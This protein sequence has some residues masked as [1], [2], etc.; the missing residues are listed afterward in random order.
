MKTLKT[1]FLVPVLD[2]VK[3]DHTLCLEIRYK[4]IE[5]YYRGGVILKIKEGRNSFT[6]FF[7][8]NYLVEEKTKVPKKL[9]YLLES[10]SDVK[11]WIN[12]VPFLKHEMDLWFGR[13]PKKEREFQ[14]LMLREN[15]FG[16]TATGTDYFI[17]DIE[18]SKSR[19]KGRF[20]LIAVHWPSSGP[21]RKNNKNLGLAFMEMKYLDN[22]LK[23]AAGLK[24]HIEDLNIF[25][26]NPDN[27]KS[28]KD[29]M[30]T[31]F[32][33]KLELGLVNNQKSIE[34]FN[35]DK[36]EYI[37]VFINHDP[38]AS[39]LRDELRKLPDCPNAELKISTSNFMGYGLYD[40]GIYELD[41]FLDKF[42]DCV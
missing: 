35:D 42:N 39:I 3:R 7:D 36:P 32:N 24:K 6:T 16:K 23:G 33:Q 8:R 27:T 19:S 40:Q 9:P 5:I 15:N 4:L 22:A 28:I 21:A 1:G 34:S 13:H 25:L 31:V 18:Y 10:S 37:L 38:A 17:C 41:V 20:D 26:K 12:A 30:K 14:Q 2:L 11:K 29:E